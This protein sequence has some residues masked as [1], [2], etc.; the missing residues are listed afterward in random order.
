M[1]RASRAVLSIW[2]CKN[3]SH[4]QVLLRYFLLTPPIQLE[5]RLQIGGRLLIAT[6]LDQW[7]YLPN[8][9][10]VLVRLCWAFNAPLHPEQQCWAKTILL[11]QTSI[12]SL[13]FV[14]FSFA[15][16]HTFWIRSAYMV[17]QAAWNWWKFEDA[18][19]K[20]AHTLETRRSWV[21]PAPQCFFL[22]RWWLC[23]G[24]EGEEEQEHHSPVQ[25]LQ[26]IHLLSGLG[27]LELCHTHWTTAQC[28]IH[29]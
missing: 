1:F 13:F 29:K 10:Q 4:I 26:Q 22:Y 27:C 15:G 28:S 6:H 20:L 7:N 17:A 16:P 5:P 3:I 11:S 12:F 8:Q 18:G 9:Q 24:K 14:Q 19:K 23:D 21:F 2:P 25:A